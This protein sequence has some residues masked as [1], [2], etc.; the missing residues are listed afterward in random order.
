MY[1]YLLFLSGC[2]NEILAGKCYTPGNKSPFYNQYIFR[3]DGFTNRSTEQWTLLK[4][5]SRHVHNV[6]L[7]FK[8]MKYKDRI[9]VTCPK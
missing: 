6:D 3:Y 5:K 4:A 1:I 8:H 9:T 2:S 7:A